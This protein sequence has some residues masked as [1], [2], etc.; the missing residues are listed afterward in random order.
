MKTLLLL[1]TLGFQTCLFGQG[2]VEAD[3]SMLSG[4]LLFPWEQVYAAPKAKSKW[5]LK[6]YEENLIRVTP[7]DLGFTESDTA[8]GGEILYRAK[9]I[10]LGEMC[11]VC[12]CDYL[13]ESDWP[14]MG[15]M[16]VFGN[17]RL[18]FSGIEP[19]ADKEGNLYVLAIHGS[20]TGFFPIKLG[21]KD[22][23]FPLGSDWFFIKTPKYKPPR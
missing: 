2:V 10:G 23:V 9:A 7:R 20:M 22:V 5:K 13:K 3:E 14:D 18:L 17:R 21:G 11:G 16:H 12:D 6:D 8:T 4:P 1:L 19:L 15:S